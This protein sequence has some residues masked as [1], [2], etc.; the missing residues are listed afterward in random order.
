MYDGFLNR[1]Q[2]TNLFEM[3]QKHPH[4]KD[5]MNAIR[6]IIH[7]CFLVEPQVFY[8]V[9]IDKLSKE[10]FNIKHIT[11]KRVWRVYEEMVR[12]KII[13]DVLSVVKVKNSK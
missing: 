12:K 7:G 4:N 8:E 13:D 11:V 6:S 3:R 10:G 5:V 1:K 9:V 2:I